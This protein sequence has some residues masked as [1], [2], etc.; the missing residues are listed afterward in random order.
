MS[1]GQPI[2]WLM[3]LAVGCSST[4][5]AATARTIPE[6][7]YTQELPEE[8]ERA[9]A[10]RRISV[11]VHQCIVEGTEDAETPTVVGPG[12]MLSQEMAVAAGRLR[13]FYDELRGLCQV[14]LRTM[15]RERAIYERNLQ[16]ADEEIQRQTERAERSWLEQNAGVLGVVGGILIGVAVSVG[17]LAA[18]DGVSGAI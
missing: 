10:D 7:I 18:M 6:P 9:P 4:A 15:D 11:A 16:L 14:D 5:P 8:P 12:I 17:I 13:V 1:W 3:I 2:A